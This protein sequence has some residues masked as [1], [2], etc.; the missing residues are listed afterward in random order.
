MWH[1]VRDII[2]SGDGEISARVDISRDSEWFS[3]HFPDDPI[4][5]GIA[6]IDMVHGLVGQVLGGRANIRRLNRI[7]F[8]K[9]IRPGDCLEIRTSAVGSG[10]DAVTFSVLVDADVVCSGSI[11]V[12][13][14]QSS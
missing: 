10:A 4:L 9:I 1:S 13:S 5:P 7:R 12:S 14:D 6:Q 3:G 8:K 11:T 2:T